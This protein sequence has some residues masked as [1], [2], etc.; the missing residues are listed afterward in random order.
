MKTLSESNDNF[1]MK[2][3]Y[4]KLIRLPIKI[5][6]LTFHEIVDPDVLG[7]F[8]VRIPSEKAKETIE[9]SYEITKSFIN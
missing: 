8:K 1:I 9:R 5:N 3:Y 7:V 4:N 2:W 6:T